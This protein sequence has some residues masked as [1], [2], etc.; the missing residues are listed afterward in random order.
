MAA[1]TPIRGDYSGADLVGFAEFQASEYV[2]IADGGTGAT[3]AT[4]ARIA[5]GLEIGA[6]VQAYHVNLADISGLAVTDG[7]I[8][9]GDG[10][11]FV[12]E[13]GDTARTSLGLG[14]TDSPTFNNLVVSGNLTV[15]GTTTT[16]NTETI[17]LADNNIVLNSN[18]TGSASEDAGIT[19][20]RG[21]DAN[22]TLIWDES[23]DYWT[24]GSETFVAGNFAGSLSSTSVLADGVTATTQAALDNSTKVA[25]TEYVD[26][27]VA[28][29]NELAEMNDVT[30]TNSQDGDFLRYNGSVW[31]NDAVDLATDTVGDFVQSITAGDGLAIDV[32][33][34][35]QQ[36]PTLSVNVDDSSIEIATDTLQVKAL[37]ITD[38]MLAGSISNAKLTN[39]KIV[40]T[41]G[42]T[43]TDINLGDT[44][45]FTG[46]AGVDIVNTAGNF[47]FTFDL[48]EVN[49]EVAEAAQ[50]AIDALLAAGTQTRITVSYDDGSNSLSYTVD[51]DLANYDNTNT[52]FIDLTDLSATTSTGVTYDNATG[53]IALASIPNT[54]LTNSSITVSD[55]SNTTDIA[56]GD[57][58]TFT[59]GAGVDITNTAGT[60]DF[61]FDL[62]EVTSEVIE[63]AQDALNSA[64]AAGTQTRIAVAYDDNADSFSFTVE[65]DL[66][67][68]D[69]TTSAFITL[70]SLSAPNADG[71][72]YDNAT[73]QITLSSIPNTSL[74]N[75]SVT[76]N[77][78]ALSLGG[79][80]TLDTDDIAESGTPTNLYF[81]DERAQDAIDAAFSAGTQTRIT[82]AYD[83]NA[84]SYSLT[85]DDDLSNYDN[86]TSAF[87][88]ADSTDTLTNK[89]FDANGTGNSISNIEVADLAGSA[90][91]IE[92]EGIASNDNDTTLPTSAAVKDY[93]D[94][95]ITDQDLDITDG[96]TTSA[97]DLD[98]QTLT[99]Q[100]TA[101]EVEVSLTGQ[102][103]TIGLPNDVT[104]AGNLTVQGT[105]TTIDSN[106]V[107]IG[108]S[109]LTLNA[110]ETGAPS[111]NGGI[112]IQRGTSS[113][114]SL[115]W[116]E[117]NDYW[118]VGSEDFV[119]TN[120]TGTL[121]ATSV[122]ADGVTATTQSAG[123]NS[124]KV[125][126][127]AYVDSLNAGS[128]MNFSGDSG[129]GNVI[130][131]SQT[132][133]ITGGTGLTS[134]VSN[135]DVT[136]D[137]DATVATL[138][139][140]QTLTNKTLGA[141]TIAGHLIPDTDVSYDLGSTN[142]KF[143][144]LY[145]SGS[146]IYL[147]TNEINVN[148]GNYEFVN[149]SNTVTMPMGATDTLVAKDT[150]DVLTNKTVVDT[151]NTMVKTIVVDVHNNKF[152]FNSQEDAVLNLEANQNYRFDLSHTSLASDNFALSETEDGSNTVVSSTYVTDEFDPSQIISDTITF[153]AAHGL[154][155]AD[156]IE[157]DS[158]GDFDIDGLTTGTKYYAIVTST[159]EIQVAM[160]VSDAN[161]GTQI[162]IANGNAS[163]NQYFRTYTYTYGSEY[164]TGLTTVGTQGQAGAYKELRVHTTTPTLFPF[165]AANTNRGGN[166]K[167]RPERVGRFVGIE[168]EDTITNKTIDLEQNTIQITYA[169]TVAADSDGNNKYFIDGEETASLALVSG[170][171][172]IFDLSDSSTATHPFRF[173]DGKDGVGTEVTAGVT[174][175]G[176][177]GTAGAQAKIAV[178]S[179]TPDLV[180]YYCQ[181]HSGMGGDS[182]L[183]VAGAD[184]ST[185][186]TDDLSQGTT[187][188]YY[189][190]NYVDNHLS[191]GTGIAY[192]TGTISVED[193]II[194]A[195]SS[196]ASPVGTDQ[197]LIYDVSG[198]S[199]KKITI[200]DIVS[201]AGAGSMS[202]FTVSDGSLTTPIT[203][204]D[205]L[206]VSGVA[207]EI[208]VAVGTDTVT[209]GLEDEITADI[210]GAVH[211]KAR[212]ESGSALTKGT[213]V[214]ISGQAGNGQDF[215]IDVADADDSAKMPAVGIL[216]ADAANNT[217]A[218]IVTHGKFI[219]IDTSSFSVGDDLYISATGT[220]TATKPAGES[221]GI[222]KIAK[223]IR[224]HASAGQI[225]VMGA[226]RTN[227]TPNLDDGDIFIGNASNQT[228]SASLNTKIS[229]YLGA[230]GDVTIGGN[231][232]VQGS[233]TTVNQTEIN[234]Q[235]AF[236]FEGATADA[237]E[238]TLS[239]E[240]PTADRIITLP[241]DDGTI[242]LN[243]SGLITGQTA[244]VGS[245]D[246]SNDLVL[247]YDASNTELVKVD[248]ATLLASAG[249][250]SFNDF[251]LQADTGTPE[252][253]ADGNTVTFTGGT[254]IDTS[255]GATDT[256][257][258][259]I[260][261][262]VLTT[263]SSIND[264]TDVDASSPQNEQV[265][266]YNS[267]TGKYEP[268]YVSG[269]G[270]GGTP[271]AIKIVN[272]LG[273]EK[274][275]AVSNSEIPFTE[276]DGT[277]DTS[278]PLPITGSVLDFQETADGTTFT[279][280]DIQLAVSEDT[281]SVI[282]D[283]GGNTAVTTEES[284]NQVGFFSDGLKRGFV[285]ELGFSIG[286]D[287]MGYRN[288]DRYDATTTVPSGQN[289]M[290]AGPITFSGTITVQG[291]LVIV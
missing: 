57:T 30:L 83:D 7:G 281:F 52:A 201:Q 23:N 284:A 160:T 93:V 212:N 130:F 151:D 273:I 207:N 50:D 242:A 239:I 71:V 34:G 283:T 186:T 202:S 243:N 145:L 265:L 173:N 3:N 263:A 2:D 181:A 245:I 102:A 147:D 74:A 152:R 241:D 286:E 84:N 115:V 40:A 49:A 140:T 203:D 113:N 199:L 252:V 209:I 48:T 73:G 62:T 88:T 86:T 85:V 257:T 183:T 159:T 117:T 141:T 210:N 192:S 105:T 61:T 107:N 98:S 22:K 67:V 272:Y 66:S 108:D 289:M 248:V 218:T 12:L 184:L 249:A 275:I 150:T 94:T 221:S 29:E 41:D 262:T 42:T 177:Q 205:T 285:D 259:E 282:V 11:N 256:I 106:T 234:V 99:I 174:Y 59:G 219:G 166:A 195:Q 31:I 126:T 10:N 178:N 45:T 16:I 271:D 254:G 279:D 68:Y 180:Y 260:D 26:S 182:V 288:P 35:E 148:S 231:L 233:T 266:Q 19:V 165:S 134:T 280:D 198:T 277:S 81:T 250:G 206:T 133:T 264:L 89:T 122:L 114:V 153:T 47:E 229:D 92:S 8:I 244:L 136:I 18:A 43:P 20:E 154:T 127:T 46:G 124:T 13:S 75:S 135:Q 268:A 4:D 185:Q 54:S 200:S 290:M 28:L 82:Y 21:D 258:I 270:G 32:T 103:Y 170:F 213:P 17:E 38:A 121:S 39:S 70:T 138:T 188:L 253:V 216:Y 193:S 157:Y 44:I 215:T 251:T 237:F 96:T 14:T 196:K 139:G 278:D 222:Q 144:D 5:L 120:L 155:T 53:V 137:I 190:D 110:D 78:N 187:N 175:T 276:H 261:S 129:S 128:N 168:T 162:T 109:I 247:L 25:T 142:L 189:S 255:V 1:K 95:Q 214:Y 60:L 80:L 208:T 58:V 37:G 191:G 91:V 146:T 220:L 87:I 63:Q 230:G 111:Q 15:S 223:V 269:G 176:D 211:V 238:T 169:V 9:V 51:D 6:D 204:A 172:Y 291:R 232:I 194:T 240:D 164:T 112:E 228:V 76:I 132:L 236:V 33:S 197:V 101:N 97:V 226:S 156:E 36:T 69:N 125:A 77:A 274:F 225:Y 163:Q 161:G 224:S 246:T 171:T 24:V 167:G 116:D 267:S 55:G 143:R 149:G 179:T 65:D 158:G 287:G 123:D 64:F 104:I 79:T 100:G 119:A 227:A 72:S 56:L 235:N 131:N 118:T 90:V 217:E 27:A